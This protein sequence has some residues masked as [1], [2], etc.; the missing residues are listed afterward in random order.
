MAL[1]IPEEY[2]DGFVVI[3]DLKE[4]QVQELVSA[5]EDE[6]PT[7]NRADLRLRIGEKVTTIPPRELD[8]VIETLLSL[9]ALRDD[10]GLPIPDF[11][12]VI[13]ETMEESDVEVLEFSGEADRNYFKANL[14]RLL[15]AESLDIAARATDLLY[16]HERTIHGLARVLTDVRPVF[17]VNPEDPPRGA[18]V[19]HTLKISY[20]EGPQREIKEFFIALDTD[21]LDELI[22]VLGRASLKAESLKQFLG[23]TVVP[24]IDAE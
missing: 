7:L 17:G 24:Y 19:T 10:M 1:R 21:Q 3:R 2:Q 16:E 14:V 11:A 20:H 9:Y 22:G 15:G 18:V 13:C 12:E 8:E 5:L 6:V 4:Q 23:G